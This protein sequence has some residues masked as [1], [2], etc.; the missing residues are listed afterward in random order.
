MSYLTE[1]Y[2]TAANVKSREEWDAIVRELEGGGL[3]KTV[4]TGGQYLPARCMGSF[5]PYAAVE[6]YAHDEDMNDVALAF[7]SVMFCLEGVGEGVCD[8]WRTY[9]HGDAIETVMPTIIWPRPQ[10]IRWSEEAI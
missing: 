10:A 8:L 5:D 9:Y 1:Y 4:F 6:W 2:L 3:V 7:P